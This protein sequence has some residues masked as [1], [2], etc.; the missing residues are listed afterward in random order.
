MKS[1]RSF[2]MALAFSTFSIEPLAFRDL[3]VPGVA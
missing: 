3:A 1:L 2:V